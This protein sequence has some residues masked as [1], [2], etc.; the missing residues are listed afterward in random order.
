[1]KPLTDFTTAI[2]LTISFLIAYLF[3]GDWMDKY[4]D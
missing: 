2:L 1:M 4:K 3:F